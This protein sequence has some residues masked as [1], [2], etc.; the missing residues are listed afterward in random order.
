[1]DEAE[2][3]LHGHVVRDVRP[4]DELE[5]LEFV[6]LQDRLGLCKRRKVSQRAGDR[7]SARHEYP[8]SPTGSSNEPDGTEGGESSSHD[9]LR[10]LE[11]HDGSATH[12]RDG[13]RGRNV[14]SLGERH[15]DCRCVL[16]TQ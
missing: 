10:P 4:L 16:P 6:G 12:R 8:G 9:I 1:M 2:G 5:V 13:Y 14:V 11:L 3:R 15:C 7:N